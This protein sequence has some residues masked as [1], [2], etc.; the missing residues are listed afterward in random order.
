M[1]FT[2]ILLAI[3]SAALVAALPQQTCDTS[4]CEARCNAAG[5][6]C[7]DIPSH[8]QTPRE[9]REW[10]RPLRVLTAGVLP[11]FAPASGPR[12]LCLQ[13]SAYPSG[14]MQEP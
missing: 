1:K 4:V 8:L 2:S 10:T 9:L 5:L 7:S 6:V 12:Y 11:R 3:T 13:V 14:R